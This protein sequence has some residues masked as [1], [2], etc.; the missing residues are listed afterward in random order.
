[1]PVVNCVFPRHDQVG[2]SLFS[3][4]PALHFLCKVGAT[5]MIRFCSFWQEEKESELKTGEE[6]W[7]LMFS[8]GCLHARRTVTGC[9]LLPHSRVIFLTMFPHLDI[10]LYFCFDFCCLPALSTWDVFLLFL[11]SKLMWWKDKKWYWR[12]KK[13]NYKEMPFFQNTLS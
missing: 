10:V 4:D 6:P 8:E 12:I 13:M 2:K 9:L 7:P 1:M 5:E 11:Y 3:S